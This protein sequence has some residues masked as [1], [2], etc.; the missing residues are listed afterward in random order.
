[1]IT[2]TINTTQTLTPRFVAIG[3]TV[4][5]PGDVV[6]GRYQ[7][8]GDSPIEADWFELPAQ[9]G[10]NHLPQ[11]DLSAWDRRMILYAGNGN[12]DTCVDPGFDLAALYF[13]ARWTAQRTH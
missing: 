2:L 8:V 9:T 7:I 1:V 5:R 3:D 13:N 6:F 12:L 4:S 10:D 11:D